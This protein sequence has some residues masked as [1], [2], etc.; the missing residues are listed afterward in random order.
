MEL[1]KTILKL[2]ITLITN[3]FFIMVAALAILIDVFYPRFRGFMGEYWVKKELKKLSK[4]KYMLLNDVMVSQNN[5]TSQI[6]HLII[7]QFGIFVI[8]TKS[9]VVPLNYLV[10]T[11]K[12]HKKI[13]LD[14]DLQGIY[15]K[16]I[17]LNI[18]DKIERKNHV[19]NIR[20]KITEDNNK[21][22]NMICPS[23]GGNLIIR[24]GKYGSFIGCSNYPKCKFIKK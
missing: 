11:I 15:N 8:E 2:F 16:I 24:N 6:D 22:N 18:T 3:P 17:Q 23:C 9:I 19:K 13:I 10:S 7:S 21:V 14:S 5:G 12:S 4:D 20:N 1:I